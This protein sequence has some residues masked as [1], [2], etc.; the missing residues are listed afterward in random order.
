M[1]KTKETKTIVLGKGYAEAD[2]C[3]SHR[4]QNKKKLVTFRQLVQELKGF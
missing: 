4:S 3:K 1:A 2:L